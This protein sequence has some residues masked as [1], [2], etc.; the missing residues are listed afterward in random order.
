MWTWGVGNKKRRQSGQ[1]GEPGGVQGE[2]DARGLNKGQGGG[3]RWRQTWEIRIEKSD[4]EAE[5]PNVA[6]CAMCF[7]PSFTHSF[8][9][10]RSEHLLRPA[11]NQ[12]D[13][14][15]EVSIPEDGDD[16]HVQ[17]GLSGGDLLSAPPPRGGV[18]G[19]GE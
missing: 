17:Y 6:L 3:R 5:S 19:A 16:Q 12:R 7:C 10:I 2:R 9:L 13:K 1:W 11:A 8:L 14:T 15:R 4:Q 18:G